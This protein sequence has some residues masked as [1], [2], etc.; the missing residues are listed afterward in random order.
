MKK[1]ISLFFVI[2]TLALAIGCNGG[3]AP[4]SNTTAGVTPAGQA[5]IGKN[6]T[7]QQVSHGAVPPAPKS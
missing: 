5:P 1:N 2:L 4:Q 7:G 6:K 3:N